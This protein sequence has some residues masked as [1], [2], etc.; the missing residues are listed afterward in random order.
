MVDVGFCVRFCQAA[1]LEEAMMKLALILLGSDFVKRQ[2]WWLAGMGL[3]WAVLGIVIFADAMGDMAHVSTHPFGSLLLTVV[4]LIV[5]LSGTWL[6][7]RAV[8]LARRPQRVSMA[9]LLSRDLPAASSTLR[10]ADSTQV[11]GLLVVH[12]WTPIGPA[13]A[14]IP[15]PLLDRYIAA[16]DS[17]GAVTTGHAALECTPDIYVSHHPVVEIDRA[18][19]IANHDVVGTFQSSYEVEAAGWCDSTAH[20]VFD[21]FDRARLA[22]FWHVYRQDTTYN[23]T[24]RNASSGVAHC[25]EAA[26]EGSLGAGETSLVAYFQV[27]FNPELWYAAQLRK[28]AEAV[29]WTPALLLDYARTLQA[30]M[31]PA[32]VSWESFFSGIRRAWR[33]GV[34][35]FAASVFRRKR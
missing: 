1:N 28:K 19:A 3:V 13:G 27:I 35:V 32:S 17:H 20:V 26:L 21:R 8:R 14:A 15:Y 2:W 30:A 9:V 16:V 6:L 34:A 12:V 11:S 7:R 31:A 18:N 5:F 29:T 25:L 4:A 33:Y 24:R 23:L 10:T 22:S